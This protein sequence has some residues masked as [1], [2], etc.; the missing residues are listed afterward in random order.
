MG[1]SDE[2]NAYRSELEGLHSLLLL[3]SAL[4]SILPC[5][6]ADPTIIIGIGCATMND[7]L[8]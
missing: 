3:L 6:S 5:S 1:D 4:W 2:V 7:V 8:I